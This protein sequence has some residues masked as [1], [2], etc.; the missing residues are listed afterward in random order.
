MN[1][2]KL[3]AA[4]KLQAEIEVRSDPTFRDGQ[5]LYAEAMKT[6]ISRVFKNVNG[7]P[8]KQERL[9]AQ[10]D[11]Y[12]TYVGRGNVFDFVRARAYQRQMTRSGSSR[13]E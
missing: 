9:L 6:A 8:K 4:I 11:E 2:V 12:L 5:G 10:Y 3:N 1:E 7:H 13:G